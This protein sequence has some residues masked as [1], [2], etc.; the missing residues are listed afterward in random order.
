LKDESSNLKKLHS[1]LEKENTPDHIFES[2]KQV[3]GI[4]T[5]G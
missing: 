2:S 4:W 5:Y 1:L 3:R